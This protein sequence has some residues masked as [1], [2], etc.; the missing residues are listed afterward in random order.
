[1]NTGTDEFVYDYESFKMEYYEKLDQDI[2]N[3]EVFNYSITEE[4]EEMSNNSFGKNCTKE[5][6]S[7]F[8]VGGMKCLVYD[9]NHA[10]DK[11]G[12]RRMISRTWLVMKIWIFIYVCVAIPCWCQKGW[13]CCC[14]RCKLCFPRKIIS[15]AKHYYGTDPPG[16]MTI[17]GQQ[18]PFKYDPS[19]LELDAFEKF[20]TALR[21]L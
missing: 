20:E 21:N 2:K 15:L 16:V 8:G 18:Q 5:E 11:V 4:P 7:R 9:F 14:F 17:K 12:L 10:K 19:E 6:L 13:C 1:M 3:N